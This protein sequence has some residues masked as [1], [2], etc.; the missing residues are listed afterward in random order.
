MGHHTAARVRRD[1]GRPEGGAGRECR[2]AAT[3]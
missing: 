2:H 1:G 3:V